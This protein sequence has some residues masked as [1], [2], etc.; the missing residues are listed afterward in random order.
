MGLYDTVIVPCPTCGKEG[1]FQS[2][3]GVC[4]LR[5]Y[6]LADAPADVLLDVNRHAPYA[7]GC[8]TEYEVAFEIQPVT[9]KF[10]RAVVCT[11]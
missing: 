5:T 9:I 6:K 11:P 7:C 3:S 10:A 1:E 4:S 2:K 8:G